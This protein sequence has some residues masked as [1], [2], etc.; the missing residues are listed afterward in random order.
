LIIFIWRIPEQSLLQIWQDVKDTA[1]RNWVASLLLNVAL[2]VL[3]FLH[4]RQLRRKFAAEFERVC[5]ERNQLQEKLG[6]KVKS[7]KP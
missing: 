6:V 1:N 7:S 4:A 3:W 2:A 5:E